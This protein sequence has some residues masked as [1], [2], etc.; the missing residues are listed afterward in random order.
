MKSLYI[1]FLGLMISS[2]AH[3]Q[4]SNDA[5][6]NAMPI[7][8]KAPVVRTTPTTVTN[9]SKAY[10]D[11]VNPAP[12]GQVDATNDG[13]TNVCANN[14]APINKTQ[15][16]NGKNTVQ[17][18]NPLCDSVT[19]MKATMNKKITDDCN[20]K[21]P[22]LLTKEGHDQFVKNANKRGGV[23]AKLESMKML[24]VNG[25]GKISRDEYVN[26]AQRA[27]EFDQLDPNHTGVID[28]NSLPKRRTP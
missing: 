3:A 21:P 2:V 27:K 18:T 25:D 9:T 16:I 24:D 14:I 4:S 28:L 23:D 12:T 20:A 6:E 17:T 22:C 11:T 7:V 1:V 8:R 26:S 19:K 10:S 5:I 13:T 15:K